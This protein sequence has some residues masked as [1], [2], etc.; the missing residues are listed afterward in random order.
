MENFTVKVK[1]KSKD[2]AA[3]QRMKL[4]RVFQPIIIY[5]YGVYWFCGF[6]KNCFSVD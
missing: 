6:H 5:N 3:Y 1:L 2:I 4:D